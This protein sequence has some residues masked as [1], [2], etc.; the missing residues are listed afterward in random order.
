M[1]ALLGQIAEWFRRRGLAPAVTLA[2]VALVG[3][4]FWT[5]AQFYLPGKG[6][7]YLIA[8]GAMKE[9]IRISKVRRLDRHVQRASAGYDAQFY[10]Q[11]AMDPSL[12]NRELQHAMDSLPYRGRRI[13]FATTA[14]AFGLG[15][16]AWILQSFALQ[17]ALSWTLLALL[18]LHWFP[19]RDWDNFLR[20]AGVLLSFGVC[21]SLRNALFDGP[22][23]LLV[24]FGV[25]LHEKGRPWLST[26]VFALG[27]LG[28]ETNLLATAAL[29]P[30]RGE[31]WRAWGRAVLRAGLVALPLALW[32][33][34]IAVNVGPAADVGAR[35]FAPP[36]AAYVRKWQDVLGGLPE[37]NWPDVGALW[38]LLVL[39]ALTVQFLFLALRPR[40][41]QAWWRVGAS[42][43][44]LMIVLGD[45]VWEGYPGAASRVLLPMQL[46]FNILVP[47][48]RGWRVVL[49]LG[50]LTLLT[51]PVALAPPAGEG[52]QLKGDSSL[53][54]GAGG[55]NVV[56]TFDQGWYSPES[57]R[58]NTWMWSSGSAVVEVTNPHQ[59]VLEFRLRFTLVSTGT[60]TVRVLLNGAEVWR[61]AISGHDV[62]SGSFATLRL[63][64]G[65]NRLEFV[66]D[67]PSMQVGSDPRPLAFSVQNLRID[68]KRKL[69][70]GTPAP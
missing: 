11:I 22:S 4:F 17:N 36:F 39:V 5:L 64:P 33:V 60:R 37:M 20:W 56:V 47:A 62:L 46:A 23:L 28:K 66:T 32:L 51:A 35:N 26:A 16:P 18:L 42:F 69:P 34:Y 45:A 38:S 7:S 40:W 54:F 61:T 3:V 24:A 25:F 27:G 65:T 12:R 14:Y 67:E 41:D 55:R 49:L 48:G 57:R 59:S 52:Y 1:R 15:Q 6:F 50:N 2:Y 30:R 44:V 21:V 31:G 53:L 70:P 43:A 9:D 29:A 68:L 10:V 13:L 58:G 63:A 19:P 8:F